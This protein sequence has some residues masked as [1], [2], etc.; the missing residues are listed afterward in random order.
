MPGNYDLH[1][2]STASDGTLTPT[3]LVERAKAAGV[4]VLALTDHDDVSGIAEASAAAIR[5]GIKLVPGIELSVT[6]AH[7]TVHIVGLNVNTDNEQLHQGIERQHTFRHW[8]AEEIARRLAKKGI[9]GARE[10]AGRFANGPIVSRTHFARFLVEQGK[11]D[12]VREVFQKYLVRGKPGYVSG[13]WASL[14]EVVHWIHGAGG[15]AVIAHP[16]RYRL[17]NTRLRQL[18]QEF[19]SLGGEGLEVVSGS[20]SR[21]QCRFMGELAVRFDFLASSGSDY[22]GPEQAYMDLGRLPALPKACQPIWESDTWRYAAAP[23]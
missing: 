23:G 3:Q 6:W 21:D 11:A 15:Q 10:G 4:D 8:R 18:M 1:S 13:D 20:Q 16:A 2:H 17:S 12:N 14:E 7:Q 9:P 5:E 22:H 19:R